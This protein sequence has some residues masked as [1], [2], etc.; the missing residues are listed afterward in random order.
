MR[1]K[2]SEPSFRRPVNL[3]AEKRDEAMAYSPPQRSTTTTLTAVADT[4]PRWSV[5]SAVV[6]VS[7]VFIPAPK[8]Y[9]R[10][11]SLTACGRRG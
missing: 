8:M 9:A 4:F 6:T 2:G 11:S 10:I 1:G 3:L 7:D 5:L